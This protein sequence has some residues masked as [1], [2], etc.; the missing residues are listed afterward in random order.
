MSLPLEARAAM[1][2]AILLLCISASVFAVCTC[3]AATHK[4]LDASGP[5]GAYSAAA[6]ERGIYNSLALNTRCAGANTTHDQETPILQ[7]LKCLA[8]DF[9]CGIDCHDG[10]VCGL[11]AELCSD[12]NALEPAPMSLTRGRA[13][14]PTFEERRERDTTR[15]DRAE[16]TPAASRMQ[17]QV[18]PPTPTPVTIKSRGKTKN[19]KK[20]KNDR[21]ISFLFSY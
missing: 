5:A 9:A 16:R 10:R 11:A 6:L 8:L 12:S 1:K 19:E 7:R 15:G 18:S 13:N 17:A 4:L 20:T 2:Y 14:R 3:C 21:N